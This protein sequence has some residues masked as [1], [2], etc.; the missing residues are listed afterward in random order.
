MLSKTSMKKLTYI[1]SL[2]IFPLWIQQ[3]ISGKPAVHVWTTFQWVY[4]SGGKNFNFNLTTDSH[5]SVNGKYDLF[6]S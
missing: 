6:I 5:I 4:Y 1:S 2:D 3:Q